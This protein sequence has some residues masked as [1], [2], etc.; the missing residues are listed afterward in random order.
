MLGTG[1][2]GSCLLQLVIEEFDNRRRRPHEKSGGLMSHPA[3]RFRELPD[4]ISDE[5]SMMINS[6]LY[7]PG[8][9]IL[10]QF[11]HPFHN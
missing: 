10:D 8:S 3:A 5:G 7:L 6:R 4:L 9:K 11:H 2:K 1:I